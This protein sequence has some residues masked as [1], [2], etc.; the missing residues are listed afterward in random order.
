MA[1]SIQEISE[2]F[3][4]SMEIIAAKETEKS[5]KRGTFEKATIVDSSNHDRGIYTVYNGSAKYIATCTNENLIEGMQVIIFIENGDFTGEK[6]IIDRCLSTDTHAELLDS[7]LSRCALSNYDLI[8]SSVLEDK[9]KAIIIPN[10]SYNVD[11]IP[12]KT[13]DP[14]EIII[15]EKN[16]IENDNASFQQNQYLGIS[17]DFKTAIAGLSPVSGDYGISVKITYNR[18]NNPTVTYNLSAKT[19]MIG[20]IYNFN[21]FFPQAALYALEKESIKSIKAVLFQGNDFTSAD[22]DISPIDFKNG[23]I[24][25]EN[26]SIRFGKD[27][28]ADSE[29]DDVSLVTKDMLIYDTLESDSENQ[30][31]INLKWQFK[32]KESTT[33]WEIND[34]SDFKEAIGLDVFK[35]HWY[36]FTNK[37][38]EDILLSYDE[39][40][41]Y[42]D[43]I[44]KIIEEYLQFYD[45][46]KEAIAAGAG[47][48]E[49]LTLNAKIFNNYYVQ[50]VEILGASAFLTRYL[51]N[52]LPYMILSSSG[53]STAQTVQQEKDS[54]TQERKDLLE[55]ML[56]LGG[57]KWTWIEEN[58]DKFTY[59][60]N[61]D[62]SLQVDTVKAI[63]EYGPVNKDGSLNLSSSRYKKKETEPLVF[64][65]KSHAYIEEKQKNFIITSN[66]GNNERYYIY[67]TDD[68]L[69]IDK[70]DASKERI[71]NLS[72][73]DNK[74]NL[75]QT[76]DLII[77]K[78]PK[79]NTMLNFENTFGGT[80]DQKGRLLADRAAVNKLLV[81]KNVINEDGRSIDVSYFLGPNE[82]F[83]DFY[84]VQR[85][86]IFDDDGNIIDN[87]GVVVQEEYEEAGKEIKNR[88]D[89]KQKD[90]N[91][92]SL[93]L[94]ELKREKTIQGT[95]AEVI[96]EQPKIAK[97]SWEH[98]GGK[99]HF[100]QAIKDM[101][102]WQKGV[103]SKMAL[104]E[105]NNF[106]WAT[107]WRY[108]KWKSGTD[109]FYFDSNGEMVTGWRQI[110]YKGKKEW[111]YLDSNG[112]MVTGWRNLEYDGS[113]DWYYFDYYTGVMKVNQK[114]VD[115]DLTF[116][117]K[118]GVEGEL[119]KIESLSL[120]QKIQ[121]SEARLAELEQDIKTLSQQLKAYDITAEEV[122]LKALGAQS[123]FI[124]P[125]YNSYL[126]NNKIQAFVIK[127]GHVLES[128][129]TMYFGQSGLN[130]SDYNFVIRFGSLV[131]E[132]FNV[133][134]N[135]SDVAL[136]IPESDA[137]TKKYREIIFEVYGPDNKQ[138]SLTN[139]EKNEIIKLWVEKF[140][141][142]YFSGFDKKDNLNF[143]SQKEN[144]LY[145][146]VAIGLKKLDKISQF[147]N[148]VLQAKYAKQQLT[149]LF[150]IHV[151]KTF[152]TTNSD[153]TTTAH[154]Q[155]YVVGSEFIVY[156]DFGVNPKYAVEGFRII[157][158]DTDEEISGK[159]E[160]A[161]DEFKNYITIDGMK[162]T[163]QVNYNPEKK[164]SG[165]IFSREKKITEIKKENG[166][167]VTTTKT[168]WEPI[169]TFPLSVLKN[170]FQI[171]LID[172]REYTAAA[173]I[174]ENE[175]VV[176][177]VLTSGSGEQN[178]FTG[179][180]V[181]NVQTT[182]SSQPT[183]LTGLFG[184]IEGKP[185]YGFSSSGTAFMGRDST[186][187]ASGNVT[188]NNGGKIEFSNSGGLIESGNPAKGTKI[189]LTK[190][191]FNQTGVFTLIGHI[192]D[193]LKV[194][195]PTEGA[196]SRILFKQ[197]DASI[198]MGLWY[199]PSDKIIHPFFRIEND[200]LSLIFNRNNFYIQTLTPNGSSNIID[201]IDI[202][203][204]EINFNEK[205]KVNYLGD[206][207]CGNL[208]GTFTAGTLGDMIKVPTAEI[209]KPNNLKEVIQDIEALRSMAGQQSLDNL[210]T[211]IT[212]LM[213]LNALN[214]NDLY[215]D[216][217]TSRNT[218]IY[219]QLVSVIKDLEARIYALENR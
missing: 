216:F 52:G 218:R 10:N 123:Y 96:V 29:L 37:S 168:E 177:S 190:G 219:G 79:E 26:I 7:P 139:E 61:P 155:H 126:S 114:A 205:F 6:I 22:E 42:Y 78:L 5:N 74:K 161:D 213:E 32:N 171:A 100:L 215:I 129:I 34:M 141:D 122:R 46:H 67:S 70:G 27:G 3:L 162:V 131:N 191:T 147:S 156:N 72:F 64:T 63:I 117:N 44:D 97:G 170:R 88:R 210:K 82:N 200:K 71:L 176:S 55:K 11:E 175:S 201:K 23:N 206:V 95:P 91:A 150:P 169:Y 20:N 198:D 158:D 103:K 136:T 53:Y 146:K 76:S 47:T 69:L 119:I 149:Q 40:A 73:I 202:K 133:L 134:S 121:R 17:A 25:V 94:Q 36:R 2:A 125:F 98:T 101:E 173:P 4:Q 41:S 48:E 193:D 182:Y 54:W 1:L 75:L 81:E 192:S 144:N 21:T 178:A 159:I 115:A 145:T 93:N 92:E 195:T 102:S 212:Q 80:D 116:S 130:L 24:F 157:D 148:I 12:E 14:E 214:G 45:E 153:K 197:N 211:K 50:L 43:N 154:A 138:V 28:A 19:E 208:S 189:D 84:F 56:Y 180:V 9:N 187:D 127:P 163:P 86:F 151:R 142:G 105:G 106:K 18:E 57:E 188:V 33:Y 217:T 160:F 118:S 120:D 174:S 68:S 209:Y 8:E 31:A 65:N 51:P 152:E 104:P 132:N 184:Y 128:S 164:S 58:E 172:D 66:D 111:F 89:E 107:G 16:N 194:N 108:I 204:G 196:G 143:I 181:G 124:N 49:E 85:N 137:D 179:V 62:K 109:W 38:I 15:F 59:T 99:W 77:W 112:A 207:Y 113:K 140:E 183:T 13:Y 165:I 185:S 186:K 30:K 166:K 83:E 87:I 60:F 199:Y 110:T 203:K 167:D 90:Y 135:I 39:K 35:I